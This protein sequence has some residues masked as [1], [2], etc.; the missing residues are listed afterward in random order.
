[1]A[2]KL[3]DKEISAKCSKCKKKR[4]SDDNLNGIEQAI[5]AQRNSLKDV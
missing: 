3:I 5:Q 2:K 4:R 1:M